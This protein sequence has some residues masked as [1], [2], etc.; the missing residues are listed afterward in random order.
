[1]CLAI[2]LEVGVGFCEFANWREDIVW[3]RAGFS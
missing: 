2:P 1:M 3:V